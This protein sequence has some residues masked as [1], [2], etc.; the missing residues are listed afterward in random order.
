MAWFACLGAGGS[1]VSTPTFTSTVLGTA[2]TT[3]SLSIVCDGDYHDYDVIEF[4]TL[5]SNTGA[6][7]KLLMTPDMIDALLEIVPNSTNYI[8]MNE[9]GNNQYRTYT[10][11]DSTTT[12]SAPS[13]GGRNLYLQ[14]ITGLTCSNMTV[15]ETELY[16]ASAKSTTAVAVQAPSGV[17]FLED[18]DVILFACNSTASDELG[19]CAFQFYPKQFLSSDKTFPFNFYQ[20]PQVITI[21][22]SIISAARYSYVCGLKFE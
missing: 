13:S 20:T 19:P 5:N 22:S 14:K 9:F 17:D 7:A 18:F 12:W 6:V 2:E 15:T 10:Y 16:K 4:E 1:S 8:N 3:T 21:S 11:D